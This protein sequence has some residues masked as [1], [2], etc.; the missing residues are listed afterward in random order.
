MPKRR[1]DRIVNFLYILL[2]EYI[3]FGECEAIMKNHVEKNPDDEIVYSEPVQEQYARSIAMRLVGLTDRHDRNPFGA[4]KYE[5]RGFGHGTCQN[6]DDRKQ[7]RGRRKKKSQAT[8][9][10]KVPTRGR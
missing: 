6:S 7:V 5:Q 3:T 4:S 1:E 2:R 9:D 8:A 10:K